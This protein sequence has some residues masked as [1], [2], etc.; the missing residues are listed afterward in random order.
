VRE[1]LSA[2]HPIRYSWEQHHRKRADY[3]ARF[4]GSEYAHLEVVR[5]RTP[6]AAQSWLT[7]RG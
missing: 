3:E 4:N 7:A 5:F 6:R 2:D 1:W